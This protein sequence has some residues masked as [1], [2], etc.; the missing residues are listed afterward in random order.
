MTP[1]LAAEI[2]IL[3]GGPAGAVVA[4]RL[5]ELG[6]D[7]L[8]VDRADEDAPARAE[9]LAPSILPI[10]ESLQLR[11][12]VEAAAF[13]REQ[14]ALVL[15]ASSAVEQKEFADAPA[16]L[17]ERTQFDKRLRRAAGRAGVRLMPAAHARAPRRLPSGGWAIPVATPEGATLVTANFLVDARGKRR[18]GGQE[19]GLSLIHI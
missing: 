8:L 13:G 6:H 17:I 10:L 5:A 16:L 12:E 7:T 1:E 4:R 14:R 18:P 11:A 19:D 3:G 2:C 9:S 15:W